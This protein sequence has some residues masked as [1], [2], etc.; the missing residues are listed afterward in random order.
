MVPLGAGLTIVPVVPWE[1]A[2]RAQGAPDHL[3][4]FYHAVSTS[5][6]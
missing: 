2:A 4:I 1:G 6:R 5:K 3:P